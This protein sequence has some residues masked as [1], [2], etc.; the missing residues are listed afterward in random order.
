MKKRGYIIFVLLAFAFLAITL[1]LAQEEIVPATDSSSPLTQYDSTQLYD[2]GAHI[3]MCRP[4]E[5][6]SADCDER[7]FPPESGCRMYSADS[8]DW[9]DDGCYTD[10]LPP[11]YNI[12]ERPQSTNERLEELLSYYEA[13][14]VSEDFGVIRWAG[15]IG[16]LG[17]SEVFG[18]VGGALSNDNEGARGYFFESPFNFRVEQGGILCGNDHYWYQC[19]AAHEGTLYWIEASLPLEGG[20]TI[21]R[22]VLLYECKESGE[23]I[24][25]WVHQGTDLDGD[26]YLSTGSSGEGRDCV[27]FGLSDENRGCPDLE[28]Y[29]GKTREEAERL[30]ISQYPVRFIWKPFVKKRIDE[31]E[32][33][34]S[35]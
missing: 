4:E 30:E 10:T 33:A 26:S 15:F 35:S 20:A 1:I 19:D 17:L 7:D 18:V 25:T 22:P 28:D 12:D 32:R 27:D 8:V 13:V 29:Q 6:C 5:D 3:N 9:G 16:T 23:N 31:L 2:A 11:G 34:F 24:Y 14:S 21:N